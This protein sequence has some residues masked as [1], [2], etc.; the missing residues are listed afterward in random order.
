V[1]FVVNSLLIKA[2]K[3]LGGNRRQRTPAPNVPATVAPFQAWR[4][5]R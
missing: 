2:T 1:S 5:Y 3:N 4:I